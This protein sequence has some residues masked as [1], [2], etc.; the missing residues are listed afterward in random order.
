MIAKINR[1]NGFRG[2]LDYALKEEKGHL[3]GGN[4]I[5]ENPRELAMEFGITRKLDE[6]IKNP[7]W[8]CS[9]SLKP[10]DELT[11][12]QWRKIT[13]EYMKD[14]G[15]TENH[16]FCVVK[17]EDTDHSHVH[18]IASRVGG[19]LRLYKGHRDGFKAGAIC[20]KIELEYDLKLVDRRASHKKHLDK[21]VLNELEKRFGDSPKQDKKDLVLSKNQREL[22]KRTGQKSAQRKAFD[23][24]KEV[25][26]QDKKMTL[27]DFIADLSAKGITTEVK[28]YQNSDKIQGLSF[29]CD[30]Y[31]FKASKL[32]H[33]WKSIQSQLITQEQ[34]KE[35]EH[36]RELSR[37]IKDLYGGSED[38]IKQ[39]IQHVGGKTEL[40]R[41]SARESKRRAR[42]AEQR[43]EEYKQN[44][45]SCGAGLKE[46]ADEFFIKRVE[47]F[48]EWCVQKINQHGETIAGCA[49]RIRDRSTRTA[50]TGDE[51]INEYSNIK[52]KPKTGNTY[53]R[54][55]PQAS[56]VDEQ[57]DTEE[58]RKAD[59]EATDPPQKISLRELAKKSINKN[60]FA[61]SELYK[62]GSKGKGQQPPDGGIRL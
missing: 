45:Q 23:A 42:E 4:M 39:S 21:A 40:N 49:A 13:S 58:L 22:E 8:H 12:D 52:L 50:K 6:S 29:G 26:N 51:S 11:D 57:R 3:I 18:I 20:S 5:G 28:K 1:G 56:G 14:L 41:A 38:L 16:Q 10:G 37:T 55:L 48:I 47:G 59:K 7:V 54:P 19:D 33:S 32:K 25:L 34:K 24:L 60:R 43:N 36:D 27:D 61:N 15:F 17:H 30:G 31:G 46:W 53:S 2:I 44:F 62:R 35:L 9:L